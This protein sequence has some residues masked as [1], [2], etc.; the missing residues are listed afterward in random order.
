MNLLPAIRFR[1]GSLLIVVLLFLLTFAM[2]SFSGASDKELARSSDE[3]AHVV[4]ALMVHDYLSMGM[5]E[6]PQRYAE[7]YYA[8]YPKVAIG[9]WPPLM[10][11]IAALWMFPFGVSRFALLLLSATLV[12][13]LASTLALFVKRLYGPILGLTAGVMFVCMRRVQWCSVTFMVDMA[14]GLAAF[15]AMLLMV[16]YFRTR[17]LWAAVA[18]G[19]S[20]GGAMLLKG[21]A[22]A[23]VLMPVF[24]LLATGRIDL[25]RKPALFLTAIIVLFVGIP[26]QILTLRLLSKGGNVI[27]MNFG[28]VLGNAR[29]YAFILLREFTPLVTAVL[30]AG[31][32]M[33]LW[34]ARTKEAINT[35]PL[36][37]VACLFLA[38]LG[39]HIAVPVVGGL[40]SRYIAT[41]EAPG[42]ILFLAGCQW[43]SQFRLPAG[44]S[45]ALRLSLLISCALI[46]AAYGRAFE[47]PKLP[48]LGFIQV[49]EVALANNSSCCSMLIASD[50]TGEGAFISEVA[51]RD[52]HLSR[53]IMRGSK[54]IS[55][56]PWNGQSFRM[57]FHSEAELARCLHAVAIDVVVVDL[58]ET[59]SEVAR[60]LLLSALRGEPDTWNVIRVK[61][62][63]TRVFDVYTRKEK[64][65]IKRESV[66]VPMPYSLG[67]DIRL[68]LP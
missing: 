7:K 24:M 21:N 50:S 17:Q 56:S 35:L 63:F 40:D 51:L 38:W 18:L 14:V 54:V 44:Q 22:N 10:Y 67:R 62:P 41:L 16:R 20:I 48:S 23:L 12:A 27:A 52:R 9:I 46:A 45:P 33:A 13:T 34:K 3:P 55:E 61:G 31:L 19:L 32:L 68:E 43:I 29:G 60:N 4:S 47:R 42:I 49:A 53:I 5:P 36:T 26:W 64:S 25:L 28:T 11:V 1:L 30:L 59:D 8:H 37:G 39:F 6:L 15:V 57:L 65:G 58:T 66:R 2:Q